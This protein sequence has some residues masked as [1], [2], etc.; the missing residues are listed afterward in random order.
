MKKPKTHPIPRGGL[1]VGDKV[2][3]SGFHEDDGPA[4]LTPGAS[5]TKFMANGWHVCNDGSIPHSA[6]ELDN[7]R[8]EFVSRPRAKP[9]AKRTT[10]THK[11]IPAKPSTR[12][13]DQ[14]ARDYR[15]QRVEEMFPDCTEV[16]TLADAYHALAS[17]AKPCNERTSARVAG[18]ASAIMEAKKCG[19]TIYISS[20]V[21]TRF[22][23]SE[24][25]SVLRLAACDLE[26]LAASALTQA[27]DKAGKR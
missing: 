2:W 25:E 20:S 14:I 3:L 27:A 17:K 24:G 11:W 4:I 12:T 26:S 10:K 9:K 16:K 1:K 8:C 21:N 15:R 7:A 5:S 13:V 6:T 18:I 23:K 22:C 19:A